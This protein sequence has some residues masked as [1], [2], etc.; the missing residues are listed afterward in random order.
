MHSNSADS[1]TILILQYTIQHHT[2]T[3]ETRQNVISLELVAAANLPQRT[4]SVNRHTYIY[5]YLHG[6]WLGREEVKAFLRW[7]FLETC[8][9]GKH[10]SCDELGVIKL[11][12][13]E[14]Y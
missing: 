4:Y 8:K 7:L 2:Y 10:T 5:D 3:L 1:P 13:R 9:Q 11:W 6:F 14:K 12:G